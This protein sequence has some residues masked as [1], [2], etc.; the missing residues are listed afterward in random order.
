[1]RMIDKVKV[2][3]IANQTYMSR[4]KPPVRL[5]T[6]AAPSATLTNFPALVKSNATFNIGTSTGYDVHF[7]D[8]AGNELAYDLDFYD[9][10]TGNG[11]WWVQIPT[12]AS[13][14][15]TTIKMVYG[16]PSASTDGSTPATVWADYSYVYHFTDVNNLTSVVGSYTMQDVSTGGITASLSLVSNAMTG[17]G[18]RFWANSGY[19]SAYYAL[20][21]ANRFTVSTGTLSVLSSTDVIGAGDRYVTINTGWREYKYQFNGNTFTT[22]AG[23]VTASMPRAQ[24]GDFYCYGGSVDTSEVSWAVN[25]VIQ[26]ASSGYLGYMRWDNPAI[27]MTGLASK[28]TEVV[29]DEIRISTTTHKSAAWLQYEQNQMMDHANY[30]TYGPE[31]S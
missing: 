1:M 6:F 26:D 27:T 17:R 8:M 23:G 18:M 11:A 21:L 31:Q 7:Q 14:G 30:T 20:S 16:D 5:I 25:G 10:V 19:G 29:L 22:S 24:A 12:L 15:P 9:P 28:P 3:D 2:S 4:Y 13:S